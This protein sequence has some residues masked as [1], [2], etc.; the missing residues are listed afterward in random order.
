M[1]SELKELN[2]RMDYL[3]EEID[4]AHSN[5]DMTKIK[6]FSDFENIAIKEKKELYACSRKARILQKP[7][8]TKLD[9]YGDLMTMEH[10]KGNVECGGFIDY[11]GYGY[12]SDGKKK[13]N[14]TVYPSDIVSGQYRDDFTHVVWYNR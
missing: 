14:I 10:F 3:R 12:Y 2:D 1:K 4:K 7:T 9:D 6:S 13:S 8:M 5:V 11:D